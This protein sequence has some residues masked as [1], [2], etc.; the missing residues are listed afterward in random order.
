MEKAESDDK[1]SYGL[2]VLRS[3]G[4]L[5]DLFAHR[6]QY[7]D[8][9]SIT[10]T[11]LA[12]NNYCEAWLTL[13]KM[14][15][16]FKVT[17]EQ[18]SEL[19]GLEIYTHWLQQLEEA[20]NSIYTLSEKEINYLINYVETNTGRGVVFVNNILCELYGICPEDEGIKAEEQKGRNAESDDENSYGL[21]VL[22]SY[23]LE[24]FPNPGKDYIT[25]TSEIEHCHF[26]LID[27]IGTVQ[28]SLKLHQGSNNIN[29]LSLKQGIY[30]YRVIT[31]NRVFTGKWIKM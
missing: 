26:E 6:G 16:Q 20:Q 27:A 21:M 19:K 18:F 25:V 11:W 24:I 8:Y 30:I 12:E 15:D 22:R 9:L 13:A 7:G 3:Y 28:K 2:T 17:E 14:H 29:T 31:G 4:L 10:E 1:D 23:G 5:R